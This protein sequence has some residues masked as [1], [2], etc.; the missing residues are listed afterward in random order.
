MRAGMVA[1]LTGVGAGEGVTALPAGASASGGREGRIEW[2]PVAFFSVV[3]GLAGTA[4]AWRRAADV[5]GWPGL[6]PGLAWLAL[7]AYLAIGGGYLAKIVRYP[8][9]ARTEWRKPVALAFLP[10][11]SIGALL[12]ATA[13]VGLAD[14]MSTVLWWLGAAG[15]LG[16]TLWVLSTWIGDPRIRTEHAHPAWF[17]PVVGNLVVPLAGAAHAPAE[18]SWFFF[19]VGLVY[20][21]VLLPVVLNRLFFHGPLPA[22]LTPT[23]AILL[24]PP[25]VAFLAYLRLGGQ[26][27]DPLARIL[28]SVAV[29][30][31]LLLAV[32][33]RS[34]RG[35]GFFL[36]WWALSFPLAAVST[37]LL[38]A[39][40][41]TGSD[42]AAWAGGGLLLVLTGLVVGLT[43]RTGLAVGRRQVCRPE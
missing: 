12:L 8:A 6:G 32:Q 43:G 30:Q 34:L 38:A 36:S 18:V 35:I 9:A 29:F 3:L 26:A 37:A 25:A 39:S 22:R 1:P 14:R 42:A 24:A 5:L 20:W 4:L 40:G 33:V 2:F 23:H 28:L 19:S 7:A 10:M 17:V 27:A 11:T 31:T 13:F 21:L 16:L 41:E 15:Q